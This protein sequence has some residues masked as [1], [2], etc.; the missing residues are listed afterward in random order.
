MLEHGR[1]SRKK[2]EVEPENTLDSG[3]VLSCHGHVF[4]TPVSNT[5]WAKV[6]AF[7]DSCQASAGSGFNSVSAIFFFF[8]PPEHLYSL[9]SLSFP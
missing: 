6:L 2:G 1:E 7:S 3:F 9:F 5:L 8:Y 4:F